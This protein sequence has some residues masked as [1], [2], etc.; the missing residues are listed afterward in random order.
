MKTIKL[1]SIVFFTL[2]IAACSS[3]KKEKEAIQ[4]DETSKVFIIT[5]DGLRWQELFYG[6]DSLLVENKEYVTNIKGL[7]EKF[8]RASAVERREVLFPFIWSEVAVMGQIHGN[9]WRGSKMNV[10][11]GMHFS[12]PG[13][14]EILTGKADDKNIFSNDKIPNPNTTIL[15]IAEK[16]ET[17]KGKVAAFGSWE[18]F[19]FIINEERSGLYVN[20][21]FRKAKG[22]HLSDKEI[23]LNELQDETP[24]PWEGVR[25]DV[26]T[27]HFA[28]ENLK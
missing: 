19:P 25:L 20:A 14:S 24:S 21:G 18:V 1:T 4:K 28:I 2:L 23:F 9:R 10:T 5:L 11:N 13:Y 27:H 6:A 16:S 8:W 17:Y 12:Y 22:D 15:E 7:K 3:E 26:F